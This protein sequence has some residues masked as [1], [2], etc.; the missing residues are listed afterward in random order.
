M[1]LV[2]VGLWLIKF[3]FYNF[4]I[5]TDFILVVYYYPSCIAAKR[6]PCQFPVSVISSAY[7]LNINP[8][9]SEDL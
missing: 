2:R 8:R 4:K 7:A 3:P 6:V 9:T 5:D 1:W